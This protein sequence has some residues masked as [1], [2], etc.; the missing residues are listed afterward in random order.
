MSE[1][2]IEK[3]AISTELSNVSREKHRRKSHRVCR[4]DR[5]PSRIPIRSLK[6]IRQSIRKI[7]YRASRYLTLFSCNKLMCSCENEARVANYCNYIKIVKKTTYSQGNE[8]VF[9]KNAGQQLPTALSVFDTDYQLEYSERYSEIAIEGYQY[10]T[11]LQKAF[12]SLISK[13]YTNFL[14]TVGCITVATYCNSNMGFKI[15]DS[16]A[17]RSPPA[18]APDAKADDS[19]VIPAQVQSPVQSSAFASEVEAE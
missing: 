7:R 9:G 3:R 6:R 18:S 4:P 16:H 10:F 11:S 19:T 15:F 14:L 17:R 2:F 13:S 12:E 8:L 1:P 5:E